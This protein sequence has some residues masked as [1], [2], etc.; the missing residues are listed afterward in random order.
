MRTKSGVAGFF[1]LLLLTANTF[2]QS[3]LTDGYQRTS[4]GL[5]Y[6]IIV[7]GKKPKGKQGDLL[8]MNLEYLTQKDSV[9]F[10]TY[11][12]E[13]GPVQFTISAPTFNGDPMEGFTLLGEGDSAIFLMQ[14]DSAYKGQ[15]MPPF[16]KPGEFVKIHVNVLS[17]MTQA[18]FEKK[19][20]EETKVQSEKDVTIIESYLLSKG[21][22]AQKTSSGLYYILE[23][24]GDGARAESGKTVTVNYTGKFLDG[25]VFDSSLSPGHSPLE[26]KLGAGQMIKGFDEGIN[27]LN[28]GGKATLII[29]SSLAWGNR[30]QG[31][32]PA[33]AVVVFDVELMGVE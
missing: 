1:A 19:K 30:A 26:F 28:V 17:M 20:A 33:N 14:S 6:K 12:E 18:E 29:P 7:D 13:M 24:Q 3:K 5:Y 11:Q 27:M 31:A 16:A 15:E 2:A 10:S 32:I 9:L 21:L 22:K 8:K 4:R 23:K 25:K